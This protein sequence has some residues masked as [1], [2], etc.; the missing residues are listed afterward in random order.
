MY[1]PVVLLAK[2]CPIFYFQSMLSF[3]VLIKA[4][5]PRVISLE[6]FSCKQ[7]IITTVS[8]SGYNK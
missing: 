8:N 7:I 5:S 4:T 6:L 1:I 2:I 3:T